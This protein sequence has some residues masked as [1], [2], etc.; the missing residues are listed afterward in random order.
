MPQEATL[1]VNS[2][3]IFKGNNAEGEFMIQKLHVDIEL[4]LAGTYVGFFTVHA[5]GY[6]TSG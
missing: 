1:T 6:S 2:E 5:L 3:F 4:K